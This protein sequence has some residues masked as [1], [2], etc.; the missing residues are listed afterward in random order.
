VALVPQGDLVITNVAL[1]D[2][3]QD[4]NGRTTVKL[5]YRK[6]VPVEDDEDGGIETTA[7]CSL[8]PAKV[9]ALFSHT[10]FSNKLVL[11]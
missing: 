7:L 5:I 2:K 8:T 3:L 9:C 10:S 1:G 4:K 6:P 11:D